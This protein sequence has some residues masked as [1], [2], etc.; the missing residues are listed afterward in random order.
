MSQRP[1]FIRLI[2]RGVRRR[3]P[4]CGQ[5]HLFRDWYTRNERCN[6]CDLEYEP[7]TGN[8][9]WCIY[10]T[11]AFFTGL[12]IIGMVPATPDNH[13]I[14]RGLVLA[15]WTVCI[16]ASIPYRKCVAIAIDFYTERG[17]DQSQARLES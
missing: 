14:G 6:G 8:S 17:T 10:F 5:G 4:R 9:W 12:I 7:L 16:L 15:A 11:T 3:C 1:F 2:R 13:W